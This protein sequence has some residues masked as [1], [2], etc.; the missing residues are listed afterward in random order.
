[1]QGGKKSDMGKLNRAPT[2]I[3]LIIDA[4]TRYTK[5]SISSYFLST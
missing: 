2:G 3:V 5:H 1:M 4:V